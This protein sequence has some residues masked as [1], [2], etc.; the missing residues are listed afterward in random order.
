MCHIFVRTGKFCVSHAVC[1]SS[2]PHRSS[3]FC[4]FASHEKCTNIRLS[5]LRWLGSWVEQ[6]PYLPCSSSPPS[7]FTHK[8]RGI[9]SRPVG[10]WW[11]WPS[12]RLPLPCF[13]RNRESPFWAFALHTSFSSRKKWA[14][15]SGILGNLT[16]IFVSG[17]DLWS[18]THGASNFGREKRSTPLVVRSQQKIS[19]FSGLHNCIACAQSTNY[20]RSS[21]CFY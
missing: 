17:S 18:D 7:C 8:P 1:S 6:K 9:A 15:F 13:A 3:E 5:A 19:S 16:Q 11:R 12:S 14:E 4:L 21:S 10:G 20:G 2:H